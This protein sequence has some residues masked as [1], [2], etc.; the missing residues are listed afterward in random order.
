MRLVEVFKKSGTDFREIVYRLLG[1]KIT[2]HGNE[3]S[4]YKLASMYAD[5]PEHFFVFK[6]SFILLI[7]LYY[8]C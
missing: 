5:S 2:P 6:V 8:K 7:N 4:C 1:Y 3:S